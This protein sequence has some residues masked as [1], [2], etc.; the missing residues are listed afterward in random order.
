MDDPELNNKET[1]ATMTN[2][3]DVPNE[4]QNQEMPEDLGQEEMKNEEDLGPEEEE[5]G[6]GENNND[7]N[8]N[9]DELLMEKLRKEAEEEG[10]AEGEEE[11]ESEEDYD[12]HEELYEDPRKD[13]V[14]DIPKKKEEKE[15]SGLDER[16]IYYYTAKLN[17][18][19]EMYNH[20][21]ENIDKFISL[22]PSLTKEERQFVNSAY[23]AVILPKRKSWW[24]I[25]NL[26]KKEINPKTKGYHKEIKI[27]IENEIKEICSKMINL[28]ENYLLPNAKNDESR[29]YY[30][31]L[32][33]D[34]Y[35]YLCEI[36]NNEEELKKN[37]EKANTLYSKGSQF[38]KYM[39]VLNPTKLTNCLNFSVF[40][41][42]IMGQ[43]KEGSNL[44]KRTYEDA[45]K[46]IESKGEEN[47]ERVV[48]KDSLFIIQLLKENFLFWNGE[49]SS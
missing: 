49:T 45:V 37:Q 15:G 36:S 33:G 26:E 40:L 32:E 39:S 42:E 21:L 48:T 41:Y 38:C 9:E 12:P 7:S 11:D 17:E 5:V 1:Q 46:R 13:S 43:K 24:T 27:N 20:M 34:Y 16:E 47:I 19:A 4:N 23:K 22:K 28:T 10:E 29:V 18:K 31:N 8:E 30:L 14:D 3:P 2:N 44:A 6:E 35:R 25:N